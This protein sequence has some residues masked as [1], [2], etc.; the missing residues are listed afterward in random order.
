LAIVAGVEIVTVG[1]VWKGPNS[2]AFE[3]MWDSS[4]RT[5]KLRKHSKFSDYPVPCS[6]QIIF[7][8]SLTN[9]MHQTP[10]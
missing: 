3:G 8:T 5:G 1:G 6:D 2:R 10:S 4:F 9:Y 7:V